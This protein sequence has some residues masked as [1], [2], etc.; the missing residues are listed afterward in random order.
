VIGAAQRGRL[1][2]QNALIDLQHDFSGRLISDLRFGYNRFDQKLNT[3]ANE[4]PLG[5]QLGLTNFNNNL[6]GISIPGL[7]PIG[8]PAF[9]PEHAVDNTFNWVWTWSLHTSHNDLRFGTDIRRIRTDGFTDTMFGSI[10]GPNGSAYFG[11]GA[12]MLNTANAAIS[13][14]GELYNAY[15][16][17]LLGAPSQVGVSNYL[18]T[19]TVRQSEYALWIG[20]RVEPIRHLSLDFGVRYEVYSP[21]EPRLPGG[22][23]FLDPTTNTLQYSGVGGVG[24]HWNYYDLNNVAPRIGF[25][26]RASDRTVI[27]GGYGINYFQTP[28]MY[29][30]FIAPTFGASSG[31]Q[32]TYSTAALSGRFGA[33][34]SNPATAPSTLQN[35]AFAGNLPGTVFPRSIETPYIQTF[36][37]Q[38]QQDFYW[39]TVLSV[40]YVGT[41][42][43]HLPSIQELN[44]S[45]P[46]MGI[47]GLPF[48]GVGRTASTLFFD[49]GLTDNYNSLQVGLNRRFAHGIAFYGSYTFSKALGYT[50]SNNLLLNPT[51]LRANYGPLDYDR[52]HVLTIG[53]TIEL[54]WGRHGNHIV[55]TILAGWQLNGVFTWA[56]GTPL[57]ITADPLSCGCAGSTVFASLSGNGNPVL[58]NGAS[59]LNPSAF[60]ATPGSNGNLGRGAIYGPGYRNYDM[61]LFKNFHVPDRFNLQLRG[62]AYN[63]TNTPRF[64]NPVTNINSPDFG[65]TVTS[66]N[67]AFGRQV[68]VA[69][70]LIF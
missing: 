70:R 6:T 22:A 32:G 56:T 28:Y 69:A 40:G 43:R 20:D 11:P 67:G 41:L 4:A 18:T 51:N 61:S 54:P 25:A 5:S 38:V 15:A 68:N 1:L 36:S 16:A 66:I 27:R 62:E 9:L 42:G 8:T 55:E 48:G 37:L 39:G 64:M 65:Q 44:A 50:N 59:F 53:H 47:A 58:E 26:L 46:G 2:G 23:T 21:L 12:T 63:L 57:T 30:G 3:A 60:A 24:N 34:T 10:F 7:A 13:P 14:Y 19:P 33:I 17:F 49:N 52:R 31:V 35:G 29:S 45:L